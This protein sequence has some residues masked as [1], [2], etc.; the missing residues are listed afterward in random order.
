MVQY[1]FIRINCK[2]QIFLCRQIDHLRIA[3]VSFAANVY[4]A[5]SI[6]N[7]GICR[8]LLKF[9]L[10][11]VFSLP[12]AILRKFIKSWNIYVANLSTVLYRCILFRL[13]TQMK[14]M[15]QFKKVHLTSK[16]LIRPFL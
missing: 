13:K 14:T 2:V 3:T 15:N 1:I 6:S 16:H 11:L 4:C 10:I 12:L 5:R 7:E 8:Y 9:H